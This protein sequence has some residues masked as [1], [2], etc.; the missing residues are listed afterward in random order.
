MLVKLLVRRL[1][2]GK[3]GRNEKLA[4][5]MKNKLGEGRKEGRE[6]KVDNGRKKV[7]NADNV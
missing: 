1:Q 7:R 6:G 4:E 2:A 5:R 3:Q